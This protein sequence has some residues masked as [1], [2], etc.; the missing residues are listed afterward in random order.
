MT[1]H[2]S[3]LVNSGMIV[4]TH[5]ISPYDWVGFHPHSP[6][7]PGEMI[8]AQKSFLIGLIF[9]CFP[10]SEQRMVTGWGAVRKTDDFCKIHDPYDGYIKILDLVDVYGIN[11][12][13]HAS[14]MDPMGDDCYRIPI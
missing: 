11:V 5:E 8:T 7:N 13:K 9:S 6:T 10:W 4:M 2:E 12:G 3:G 1:F 14:P